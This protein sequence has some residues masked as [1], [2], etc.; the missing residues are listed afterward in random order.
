MEAPVSSGA[1]VGAPATRESCSG[2]VWRLARAPSSRVVAVCAPRL[3]RNWWRGPPL[4]SFLPFTGEAVVSAKPQGRA[5]ELGSGKGSAGKTRRG[6]AAVA[7]A[8]AAFSKYAGGSPVASAAA[9]GRRQAAAAEEAR[10]KRPESSAP[11]TRMLGGDA[12]RQ[13]GRDL[14]ESAEAA[15]RSLLRRGG[16]ERQMPRVQLPPAGERQTAAHRLR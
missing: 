10:V 9:A 12:W 16:R 14:P 15:V 7:A 2:A 8:V 5:G 6:T 1:A 11:L 4:G 13:G 3:A